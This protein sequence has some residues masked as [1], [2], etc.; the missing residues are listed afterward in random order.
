[1]SSVQLICCELPESSTR[2]AGQGCVVG[3][4]GMGRG[5]KGIMIRVGMRCRRGGGG[6]GELVR[7]E[8]R[9]E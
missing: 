7:V 2:W 6:E 5:G 4:E 8:F 1:M 3:G 9:G